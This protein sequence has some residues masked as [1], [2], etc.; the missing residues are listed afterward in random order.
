MESEPE[1]RV[2]ISDTFCH[3]YFTVT[4]TIMYNAPIIGSLSKRSNG[5]VTMCEVR[6]KLSS[7]IIW[8]VT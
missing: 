7:K 3:F 1:V 6:I 5:F 8:A 4:I 2:K